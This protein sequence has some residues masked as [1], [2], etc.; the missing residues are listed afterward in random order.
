[1]TFSLKTEP[2]RTANTPIQGY[3]ILKPFLSPPFIAFFCQGLGPQ[4]SPNR[5]SRIAN[6]KTRPGERRTLNA[7]ISTMRPSLSPVS[8]HLLPS[9]VC[10]LTVADLPAVAC[11][12]A[13]S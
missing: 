2:N 12:D 7:S 8:I 3:S 1:M 10:F 6:P 13:F 11:I 5:R 9:A 4:T